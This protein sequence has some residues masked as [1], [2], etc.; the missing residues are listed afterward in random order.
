MALKLLFTE[1]VNKFFVFI[2]LLTILACHHKT[3]INREFLN[4]YEKATSSFESIPMYVFEAKGGERHLSLIDWGEDALPTS[5]RSCHHGGEILPSQKGHI[6][7]L[8]DDKNLYMLISWSDKTMDK[9]ITRWDGKKGYWINM[10]DDGIA[11]IFSKTPKFDCT[12]TCHMTEWEVEEG[13]FS[14]DY[15]MLDKENEYPMVLLRASKTKNNV[16]FMKL[17][18]NGK[19]TP[20]G[21]DIY[22][23]NS[24]IGYGKPSSFQ[25]YQRIGNKNDRPLQNL[26]TDELFILNPENIKLPGKLEYKMGRWNA[27][28]TIP[29]ENLGYK[30][31]KKGDKIF[32][33]LAI[34]DNTHVN[35]GI[36]KT[37]YAVFE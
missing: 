19:V 24:Q 4:I 37:F 3:K 31:A 33:A 14:S 29:L 30:T 25:L 26:Q 6:K 20:D 13:R 1:I 9:G 15:K 36:T 12:A 8:F 17:G 11:L 34:F 22:L 18:K 27:Y 10:K 28:I 5:T 23:F 7:A 16:I 32:M 21:K 35:H 2:F